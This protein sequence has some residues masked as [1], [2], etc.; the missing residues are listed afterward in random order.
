[1][2]IA[3][4][5]NPNSGKTTLFNAM[6]GKTEYVG[7]WAG[8]TVEKKEAAL[9]RAFTRLKQGGGTG[10]ECGQGVGR[11]SRGGS[12]ITVTDLPGAYS[13]SPYTGEEAITRDFVMEENPDV[14]I[15]IVDS[16]SLERSLFFTTQLLE[17]GI[18]V[19]V[20][21]NKQD[22]VRKR[23]DSI[24]AEA[25]S[26][27]LKCE[28]AEITAND[29]KGLKELVSKA[30][31]ASEFGK[32][33][34]PEFAGRRENAEAG[35]KKG[36]KSSGREAAENSA[37][38]EDRARQE[39]IK[40]IVAKCYV[41]NAKTNRIT[42]SDKVDRIVANT[43]LGLPI[44]ALI[45]WAVYAFSISGF[46][47]LV[48]GYI[49]DTLF[50][51]IVPDAVNGFL[52]GIGVHPLMQALIVDGAIGGVGAVLGFIP[53]IMVLFFCL[54]LLEDSGYMAR[55]A[56]IMDR[57]FKRIGLS[58]KS[59]IPMIVGTGCSIPGVMAARTIEDENERKVTTMLTPF[60]PC[61]A[62]L[63]VIALMAAV[64]FPGAAWVFPG[65]YVIAGVLIIIGGLL[66]K[67][68]FGFEGTSTFIFEL[69]E[70]K[71]PS[72]KHAFR[73]MFRQAKAFIIKASTI[74][75]VMNTL[76]WFMQTYSWNLK[77]VEDQSAS[78][79]ASVG[80]IL[81]PLLLPLGFVGWQMAAPILTGFI[82]KENV[83]AT[84]AIIL[85][86]SDD[87]LHMAGGPLSELFTPVTALSFLVF[88]LFTPPCF[89]AIGAMNSELGGKK[90]LK[91][92]VLFQLGV[93][94]TLAM[95]VTQIGTL[96]VYGK[97]AVGFVPAVI[98]T[99]VIAGLV[100][101]LI[102]R[103]GRESGRAGVLAGEER[104]L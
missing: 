58:G 56:V 99:V 81:A 41:K 80:G 100:L 69:P 24:D 61:G 47:G 38:S 94:Y 20:A 77:V 60:V 31:R 16:G 73:Q 54:A 13:I 30:V 88:N 43:Y 53:L 4:A 68:I 78:I 70:Y 85:A 11:S 95:L 64:F 15:N 14:I 9:K 84:F 104:A 91:R 42:F 21:L 18:P 27:M 52:E 44:F 34:A 39:Y 93:G 3:L 2:K 103:G 65:M 1:M 45:M 46:G 101:Y 75:L 32:Q 22:I 49:N 96:V 29:G 40:K 8:V 35:I 98:V 37:E 28:V 66:L 36:T 17:L 74:I 92:A 83:V 19:V 62:K 79:L 89:A 55:V 51:A 63:P 33:E 10:S 67:R 76:V 25:L 26:G 57:Y 59:V 72:L 90:W 6:T 12:R 97:F 87:A 50:G 86:A 102:R 23:G 5:G 82:A 71:I 48:S 7:N